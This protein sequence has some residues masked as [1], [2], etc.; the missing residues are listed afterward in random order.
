MPRKTVPNHRPTR[1][2][3]NSKKTIFVPVRSHLWSE[4]DLDGFR[5]CYDVL[6]D[7]Y[8]EPFEGNT[9]LIEEVHIG[10][11]CRFQRMFWKNEAFTLRE[12][13]ERYNVHPRDFTAIVDRLEDVELLDREKCI[14]LR[15][16]PVDLLIRTPYPPARFL[17]Q[18]DRLLE[19]VNVEDDE[20]RRIGHT[21]KA[22]RQL[23]GAKAN[24]YPGRFL[25]VKERMERI[26]AQQRDVNLKR[27]Q[28]VID[29]VIYINVGRSD[30]TEKDFVAEVKRL[31]IAWTVFY[32]DRLLR[33]A[34]GQFRNSS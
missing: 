22:R 25:S 2:S 7:Y 21:A 33:D 24:G 29:H 30:F 19:R 12:V 28:E 26:A 5:K 23:G 32:D 16:Q 1:H 8:A 6:L 27:M 3:Q 17:Q 4:I 20:G 18:R 15:G 14:D 9:R 10:W 13:E 11:W 34:I 31:C